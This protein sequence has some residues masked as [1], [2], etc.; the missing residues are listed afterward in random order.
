MK[1]HTV[2]R[3]ASAPVKS[4]RIK[5][6]IQATDE[7]I[8]IW[9]RPAPLPV[10]YF[11]DYFA[12]AEAGGEVAWERHDGT[13]TRTVYRPL[14]RPG[15]PQPELEELAELKRRLHRGGGRRPGVDAL[16]QALRDAGVHRDENAALKWL[17][18]RVRN[19]AKLPLEERL[20]L[21][22]PPNREIHWQDERG[23]HTTRLRDRLRSL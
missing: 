22:V 5:G 18:D 15:R 21:A 8:E 2:K 16:G 17:R 1:R 23:Q 10:P 6:P 14:K 7:A 3:R 12:K 20:I 19:D 13:G 11:L 9:I 4:R